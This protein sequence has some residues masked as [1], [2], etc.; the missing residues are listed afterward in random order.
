[1]S[2][3]TSARRVFANLAISLDGKIDSA[4]REGGG[5]SSREDRERLDAYR[6]EADALV[7]GAGT[8]RA[9][10]PPLAIR[11]AERRRRRLE[12]GR[13]EEL[14]V[15]VVSAS[16]ELPATARFLDEPARARW[17]VVPEMLDP[18]R[19]DDALVRRI[20]AGTL[21][22]HRIGAERVDLAALVRR[23]DEAGHAR[24]LVEGGGELIAA[25]LEAD[26]LDELRVTLC[27]CLLGGRAAPTLV[28]GEGW[29]L[30]GRR[31]LRLIA[32]EPVG[33]ELFLRYELRRS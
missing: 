2:E 8:V 26:A 24:I 27:P 21:E 32:C 15:V 25:F 14:T 12:E 6:A 20:G 31:A 4:A 29:P 13:A 28:G 23:L 3:T 11:S 19:L 5:F 30:A 33:D 18:K 9:E 7:V 10:D 22:L 17:L 1:M 16:G